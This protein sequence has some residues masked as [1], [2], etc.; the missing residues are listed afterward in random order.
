MKVGLA[1]FPLWT[2]RA[3]SCL[4]SGLCLL[5]IAHL[6]GSALLPRPQEWRGMA[7]AALFNITAWQ[8]FIAAGLRLTGSGEAAVVAFTMPL[9]AVFFAWLFLR[10][11][12]GLRGAA[13]LAL[14]LA[15]IAV[16]MTRD[17]AA[18]IRAPAGVA[19][20]LA[21]AIGWAIG[22]LIQKRRHFSLN[23]MA[24]AGWQLTIGALPMVAMVPILEPLRFPVV[25]TTAWLMWA[26]TTFP[27]L[28]FCY[29][30]WFQVVKL[31][32]VTVASISVLLVPAVGVLSGAFIL[33]EPLGLREVTALVLIGA[34]LA[35]VLLL[36]ARREAT[37]AA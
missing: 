23:A 13:A 24:L 15:G 8:M 9:W 3:S 14:G 4:V 12:L 5:A 22:T 28:V 20:I 25:S 35:L 1:E 17:M 36:P 18:L 6:T 29:A 31:M 19:L 16:L 11:P 7:I 30:A 37:A 2:F 21:G 34:A 10:E 33:G 32:P 27:A 26:Y